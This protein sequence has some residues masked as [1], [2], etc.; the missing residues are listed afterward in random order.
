MAESLPTT[1]T[2]VT[3]PTQNHYHSGTNTAVNEHESRIDVLELGGAGGG[4]PATLVDAKGDIIVATAADVVAR[5][6]VGAEGTSPVSRA[7]AGTGIAWETVSGGT[8]TTPTETLLF[9]TGAYSSYNQANRVVGSGTFV[10]AKTAHWVTVDVS[11]QVFGCGGHRFD[12]LV[13]VPATGATNRDYGGKL[14]TDAVGFT[15]ATGTTEF[16]QVKVGSL[17]A[18]SYMASLSRR[19]LLTGLTVGRTYTVELSGAAMGGAKTTPVGV[20][21]YFPEVTLDNTHVLAP[22]YGSARVDVVSVGLRAG[23]STSGSTSEFKLL[24]SIT[25]ATGA[26]PY[27][28]APIPGGGTLAAVT[29]SGTKTVSIVD[30]AAGTVVRTTA[31]MPSTHTP[32][33]VA[34]TATT[35]YVSC[36]AGFIYPV[37]IAT[38]AIGTGLY[39]GA[40]D[41]LYDCALTPDGTRLWVVGPT[42][43]AVY[44]VAIPAFTVGAGV[45]LGAGSNP[46]SVTVGPDQSAWVGCADTGIARKVTSALALGIGIQTTNHLDAV[47]GLSSIG[48]A[49]DGRLAYLANGR[50]VV[51][52]RTANG[53]IVENSVFEGAQHGVAVT[54]DEYVILSQTASSTLF[55]WPSNTF[56]ANTAT[57]EPGIVDIHVEGT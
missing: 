41:V 24:R 52:V 16:R 55:Q 8:S 29:N 25:L 27:H 34:C 15:A 20:N 3:P 36:S 47:N 10:A 45:A 38:G 42:A 5:L 11:G 57:A 54:S 43:N 30:W 49:A 46:N 50:R 33:G 37:T 32:W 26:Q 39:V 6:A 9:L 35:A 31:A 48:L 21:P 18:E 7:A 22:C 12:L 28:I 51:S 23:Y 17:P 40:T 4:I 1:D 2:G 44:P 19:V 14:I 13:G 53:T 56:Q